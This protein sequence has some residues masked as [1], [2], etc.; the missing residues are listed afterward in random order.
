MFAFGITALVALSGAIG[1]P[2]DDAT[3]DSIYYKF[4]GVLASHEIVPLLGAA[5]QTSID[6]TATRDGIFRVIQLAVRCASPRPAARPQNM[7]VVQEELHMVLQ[8]L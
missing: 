5:V 7:R 6:N 4:A 8:N 3:G 2:T 1:G